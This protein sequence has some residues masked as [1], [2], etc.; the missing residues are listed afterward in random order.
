[1]SS[2]TL[3]IGDTETLTASASYS[4]GTSATAT[5]TWTSSNASV[6]SIGA[7]GVV[8]AHAG[9]TTTITATFGGQSDVAVVTVTAA[10][11]TVTGLS[12][13][14]SATSVVVGGM[15]TVMAT[16]SYSDGT[17]GAVTPAWSSS[18]TAVAT[19]SSSGAVTAVAAGTTTITGTFAGQASSVGITVVAADATVSSLAVGAAAT[20]VSVGATTTVTATATYSDG[21]SGTVNPNRVVWLSSDESLATVS[22]EGTVTG[23]AVGT[24]T[25]TGT[26]GGESGT[27]VLTVVAADVTVTEIVVTTSATTVLV[28]AT[29]TVTATASYSDGTSATISPTWVSSDT[30]VATVTMSGT[31]TAVAAGTTTISGT[32]DGQSGSIVLTVTAPTSTWRGI[33]VADENRCSPYDSG[34]YSY[35]Q[36]VED[37]IIDRLGGIYSP[38]TGECFA[39]KSETD[40]EH[41]VARSEAH[42]S[43]LCAADGG[44]RRSFS[45]DLD[46]LT[47]A[48]P[49]VN[50]NQK[51]AKDAADW[52]PARNSCWFAA[53]IVEV[54]RRYGLTIDQREAD[55]LDQVLASCTSTELEPSDCGGGTG[56]GIGVVINEFRTRGPTGAN[57]EFIELRNNSSASVNIGGWQVVGSNSSGA[58]SVRRN[59]PSGIILGVGCHYLLGNS[60]TNGYNGSTDTTYGVGITDTGGI[61]LRESDGTVVD[62][63]GL[64][65]GSAFQEGSPLPGFPGDNTNHSYSRTD[66][67][68][69]N[70]LADFLLIS[71]STPK[72]SASSC[73]Q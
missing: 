29:V 61:A 34:D 8:T 63:V 2:L 15:A 43:G 62:Q 22:D 60:N 17:S 45:Q 3:N 40:I 12:V 35:P 13:S 53:T 42:D 7:T 19:V 10:G 41:M 24:T 73:V 28:G 36:S 9:G 48:S 38:Y 55:A 64:S 65:S 20:T 71:P 6:A 18:N 57:D 47:L 39:G 30:S 16:A 11:A 46:N 68:T 14:A 5:A 32:A 67:D 58:T 4:D 1:M 49:A 31:V 66:V 33:V 52:L 37:A 21:T 70:N 26:F 72:T 59:I 69:N 25:I 51:G 56:S 23:V 50:R 54:R 27:V 44:T